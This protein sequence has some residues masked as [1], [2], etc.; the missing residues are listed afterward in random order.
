VKAEDLT[1]K[2]LDMLV[3]M[4]RQRSYLA[5]MITGIMKFPS[6]EPEINKIKAGI[7][8][9]TISMLEEVPI[10]DEIELFMCLAMSEHCSEQI[11]IEELFEG[12]QP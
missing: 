4:S 9:T 1:Q 2:N 8:K 7:M 12:L 3:N 10:Q 5:A 11:E 6:A